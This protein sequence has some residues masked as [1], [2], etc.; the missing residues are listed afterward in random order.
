MTLAF[1]SHPG[2]PLA[3]TTE[4]HQH[5]QGRQQGGPLSR[6]GP[7]GL[8]QGV[9]VFLPCSIQ[10]DRRSPLQRARHGAGMTEPLHFNRVSL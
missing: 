6:E 2:D 8:L 9:G 3:T 10:R 7:G 5:G 4:A 1:L